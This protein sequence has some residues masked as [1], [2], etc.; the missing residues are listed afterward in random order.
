MHKFFFILG[1]NLSYFFSSITGFFWFFKDVLAIKKQI[2]MQNEK[3]SFSLFPILFDK[4]DRSGVANGQYFYQDIYVAQQIYK[5]SPKR[6]IDIGSRV[7]GFVA[8]V[9]IF[10]KIDVMDIRPLSTKVK[11][12]NFISVH[13]KNR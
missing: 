10:R 11:N 9:A 1:I 3:W 7:D 5:N 13:D 4:N 2:R 6:H 12:I 8:Q